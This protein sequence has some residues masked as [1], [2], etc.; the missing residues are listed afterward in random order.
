MKLVLTAG[1]FV[2]AIYVLKTSAMIAL[3]LP[4]VKELLV[5]LKEQLKQVAPTDAAAGGPSALEM[6]AEEATGIVVLA[7]FVLTGFGAIGITLSLLTR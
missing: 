7:S 5:D 1:R 3:S 6:T 4:A 2:S